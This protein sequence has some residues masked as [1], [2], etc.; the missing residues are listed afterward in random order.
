MIPDRRDAAEAVLAFWLDEVGP[1]GWYERD[2]ALDAAI[3]RRF[4]A[5]MAAAARDPACAWHATARSALAHLVLLDQ[6]PRNI[7]RGRPEAF[8]TDPLA[9]GRARLALR[10]GFDLA[11]PEPGRQFFYLPLMHSETLA[12]QSLCVALVLRRLP[13][14]G[15]ENLFHAVSHRDVIRRFGRF[16][17]RNAAL[18]RPDRPAEIAYREAGGYMG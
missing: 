2:P 15:G 7:H 10:R 4:G 16:P 13:G 8:A 12:D 9:R 17:S 14:S 3:A 5:L 1:D 6:F 11:V 18:G